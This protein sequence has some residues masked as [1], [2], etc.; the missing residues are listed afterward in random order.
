MLLAICGT[1]WLIL[2]WCAIKKGLTH[3]L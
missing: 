1:E 3:T 2:C